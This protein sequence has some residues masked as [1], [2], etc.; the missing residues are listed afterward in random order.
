MCLCGCHLSIRNILPLYLLTYT[1]TSSHIR[2]LDIRRCRSPKEHN[3]VFSVGGINVAFS[4]TWSARMLKVSEKAYLF[5]PVLNLISNFSLY[6][7]FNLYLINH[8]SVFSYLHLSLP[9]KLLKEKS[10]TG[11][12]QSPL[13][14]LPSYPS[15]PTIFVKDLNIIA[16][17]WH[18]AILL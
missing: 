5:T 2:V 13:P 15:F 17:V 14:H 6:T 11:L 16:V 3:I 1:V 18:W 10:I 4:F 9:D 7:G 8:E 12:N